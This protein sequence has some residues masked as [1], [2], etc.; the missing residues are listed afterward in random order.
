MR[1]PPDAAAKI[2]QHQIAA[3]PAD[4]EAERIGAVRIERHRNRRLADPAAQ[5]RLALQEP[6]RLQ[7]VHDR[8]RR[9][10]RKSRQSRHLDLGQRPEAPHE[11]EQQP[12]VVEPDAGLIGA[13]DDLGDG[14]GRVGALRRSRATGAQTDSRPR[15]PPTLDFIDMLPRAWAEPP[16]LSRIITSAILDFP[17][18]VCLLSARRRKGA[19]DAHKAPHVHAR[20]QRRRLTRWE[21]RKCPK[22][23]EFLQPQPL[24]R[25]RS[26]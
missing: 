15:H 14:G 24:R 20:E 3:A 10:H 19:E 11:G 22:S 5:R 1:A 17:S 12:L 21:E 25:S 26:R 13:A 23:P 8:R 4:L 6:V 7:P 16:A 2:D 9:L 18:K